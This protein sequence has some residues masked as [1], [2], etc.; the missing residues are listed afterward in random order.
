[1][2]IESQDSNQR[3]GISVGL[4]SACQAQHL[5]YEWQKL[6]LRGSNRSETRLFYQ[7]YCPNLSSRW[8]NFGGVFGCMR[9]LDLQI[10]T[11]E[12]KLSFQYQLLRQELYKIQTG[13]RFLLRV[14]LGFSPPEFG[15]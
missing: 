14:T 1:M 10:T 15:T 13:S 7:Q 5:R 12:L 11:P 2:T 9:A 6:A 4:F 3:N 8:H